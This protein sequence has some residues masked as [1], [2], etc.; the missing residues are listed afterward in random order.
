MTSAHRCRCRYCDHPTDQPTVRVVDEFGSYDLCGLHA[1]GMLAQAGWGVEVTL[2][3]T[4][5]LPRAV[6]R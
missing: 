5:P 2:V 3:L 4:A 6:S 1:V